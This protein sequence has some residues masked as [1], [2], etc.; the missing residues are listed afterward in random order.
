MNGAPVARRVPSACVLLSLLALVAA[1]PA[2]AQAQVWDLAADWSDSANPNG[3]WSYMAGPSPV[4]TSQAA[5]GACWNFFTP[6]QSAW[7]ASDC[8]SGHIPAWLRLDA[9]PNFWID[10]GT[11]EVVVHTWDSANG[12]VGWNPVAVKWTSPVAGPVDVSGKVWLARHIGRNVVAN[13]LVNGA[14][15][16]TVSLVSG[17][18]WTRATPYAFSHAVTVSPGDTVAIEMVTTTA[19]GDFVG[20]KLTIVSAGTP[21]VADTTCVSL[22]A[23]G[24][25]TF[26]LDA[27]LPFAGSPYLL[28]GSQ[29]GTS[30]GFAASGFVVPLNPDSWFFWT[31]ANPNTPPFVASAALLDPAGRATAQILIP[32]GAPPSLAGTTGH[33]AFAVLGSTAGTLAFVSNAVPLTLV[34]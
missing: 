20:A 18:S 12:P 3:P 24:A 14:A 26:S 22:A 4:P 9:N 21:L 30:P 16:D 13:V 7:A 25:Q 27:G 19:Y 34:P 23:G 8:G 33:H 1:L 32:S 31:I 5:W 15:I 29:S 6:D 10:A 17:G 28:A 2:R 11:G